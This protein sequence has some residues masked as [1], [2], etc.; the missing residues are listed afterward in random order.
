M[1]RQTD[2]ITPKSIL[3][4][5]EIDLMAQLNRVRALRSAASETP[6]TPEALGDLVQ[7]ALQEL[8]DH[9]PDG[10]LHRLLSTAELRA[11]AV[12]QDAQVALDDGKGW[13]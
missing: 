9:G 6:L 2:R 8:R 1:E 4:D 7:G 5:L 10:I 3:E 13:K 12:L 11:L